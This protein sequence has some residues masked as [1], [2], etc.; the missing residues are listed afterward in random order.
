MKILKVFNN[1]YSFFLLMIIALFIIAPI[2][3]IVGMN[4]SVTT[5]LVTFVI[6]MSIYTA[7]LKNRETNI[8]LFLTLI[9][10]LA[11]V[12]LSFLSLNN[13][14]YLLFNVAL[15]FIYAKIILILI[16]VHIKAL[17]VL[18]KVDYDMLKVSIIIYILLGIFW[19]FIYLLIYNFDPDAFSTVHNFPSVAGY[20]YSFTVLT[21]LGFGDIVPVN[22]LA[23]AI[24]S[25][26]AICGQIYI[27]VLV[28]LLVGRH[29]S[30]KIEEYKNE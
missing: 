28:A 12:L 26:E 13:L 15:I 2:V 18:E 30:S 16:I 24:T 17:L 11:S 4:Y 20:Y 21:T 23:M 29:L 27:S 14:S 3:D 25:L 5:L 8:L 19:S 22:K 1:K 7:N 6:V 9:S 10:F